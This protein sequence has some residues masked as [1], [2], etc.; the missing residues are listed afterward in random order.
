ME[1]GAEDVDLHGPQILLEQL[2][3]SEFTCA[4]CMCI[5]G[6]SIREQ[7]RFGSGAVLNFRR[8]IYLVPYW[9]MSGAEQGRRPVQKKCWSLWM[10]IFFGVLRS[11]ISNIP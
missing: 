1:A 7:L 4:G 10:S 6:S 2:G 8:H 11:C 3:L 5:S 9:G